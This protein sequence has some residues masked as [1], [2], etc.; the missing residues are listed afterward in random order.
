[1]RFYKKYKN[2]YKITSFFKTF[3]VSRILKFNR[4]KWKKLQLFL[5]TKI[6]T[7][8]TFFNHSILKVNY[9]HW[10]KLKNNYKDGLNIKSAICNLFDNSV[11][12][13]FFKKEFLSST[14]FLTKNLIASSLFKLLYRID[15]LLW[16]LNFFESSFQARQAINNSNVLVNNKKVGSTSFVTKGDTISLINVVPVLKSKKNPTFLYSFLEVD[17]YSNTVVIIKDLFQLSLEDSSLLSREVI[18]IKKFID[19]IKTK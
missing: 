15:I 2:Y 6:G 9:K 11:S 1:M 5:N 12:T 3:P 18:S 16:K 10:D 14:K 4:P 13:Q 8:Q 17:Y 7:Q 19:Y